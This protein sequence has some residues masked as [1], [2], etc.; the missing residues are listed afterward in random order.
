MLQNICSETLTPLSCREAPHHV[1]D[2]TG[3]TG[4]HGDNAEFG[5]P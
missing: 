1:I 2:K 5:I 4:F 3:M